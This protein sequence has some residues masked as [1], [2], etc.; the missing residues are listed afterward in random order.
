MLKDLLN[1]GEKKLELLNNN[2]IFTIDELTN[3]KFYDKLPKLT[4]KIIEI[5]K[6]KYYTMT[7]FS[8]LNNINDI[9]DKEFIIFDLE[10]YS[11]TGKIFSICAIDNEGKRFNENI[12]DFN[13]LTERQIIL[14]FLNFVN[15]K[16]CFHWGQADRI[17]LEK[18][19][20]RLNMEFEI[21][22]FDL[23]KWCI[24]NYI[25]FWKCLNYKLKHIGNNLFNN[26][27]INY[28]H[29]N[30]FEGIELFNFFREWDELQE[31]NVDKMEE[32]LKYNFQDVLLLNEIK[33]Y[34]INSFKIFNELT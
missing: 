5:N 24:N 22:T 17:Y 16:K 9:N 3:S 18:S 20:I 31:I 21:K 4:K 14:N 6:N 10:F 23:H 11:K 1:I 2:D 33:N 34:L 28:F 8:N 25:T 7:D 12:N 26:N 29:E 30:D 19:K 15:N 13:I 32:I 27:L